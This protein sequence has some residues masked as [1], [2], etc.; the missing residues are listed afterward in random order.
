MSDEHERIEEGARRIADQRAPPPPRTLSESEISAFE[1]RYQVESR[2]P[3]KEGGTN[4]L[5]L[6][7]PGFLLSS[8]TLFLFLSVAATPHRTTY[9][10][11]LFSWKHS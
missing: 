8:E 7:I 9:L 6:F 11:E 5:A 2:K 3:G 4:K 1:A 10:Q